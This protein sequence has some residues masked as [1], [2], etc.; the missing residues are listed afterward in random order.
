MSKMLFQKSILGGAS[1]DDLYIVNLK[2]SYGAYN[3][4]VNIHTTQSV[5]V[6]QSR[7]NMK[8]KRE[9]DECK[10]SQKTHKRKTNKP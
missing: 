9:T 8:D 5:L 6:R 3:K 10:L 1:A 2:I 4:L 7:I